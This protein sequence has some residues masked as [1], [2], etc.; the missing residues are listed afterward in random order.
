M[1]GLSKKESARLI[2][3]VESQGVKVS[4]VKSGYMLKFPNGES[5]TM[6]LTGSDNRGPLNLRAVLKRNGIDWP[7]D[8]QDI[9]LNHATL[10]KGS[11]VLEKMGN[12]NTIRMHD[13]RI[14]ATLVEWNV[15]NATIRR[16]LTYMGY[17][18]TGNT[19]ARRYILKDSI[20]GK[21]YAE[22]V[23]IA[24]MRMEAQTYS[25]VVSITPEPLP[26]LLT[27]ETTVEVREFLDTHDSW[28]VNMD[29]LPDTITLGDMKLMF[30]A[31][32]I[33]FEVRVWK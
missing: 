25:P 11:E 2:T 14:A 22:A 19:V 8:N 26:A 17:E 7:T 12:P 30:A 18:A 15:P 27:K 23:E 3:Y 28:T 5:T 9:K 10:R 6:H 4:S 13:F 33:S 21:E 24:N 32:G 20:E 31:M 1:A 16:F 29:I